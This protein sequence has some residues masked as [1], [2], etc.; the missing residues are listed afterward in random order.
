MR[1]DILLWDVDGTLMNFKRAEAIAL[2]QS[3]EE[4]GV[5]PTDELIEESIF[6]IGNVWKPEN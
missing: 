2:S 6:P 4:V 5:E 3:L 1:Y